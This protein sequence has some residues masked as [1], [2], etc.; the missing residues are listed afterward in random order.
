MLLLQQ[1]PSEIQLTWLLQQ[2]LKCNVQVNIT[3]ALTTSSFTFQVSRHVI[4]HA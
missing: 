3:A 2:Y 4:S 1:Q